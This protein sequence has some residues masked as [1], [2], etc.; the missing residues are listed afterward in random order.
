[1]RVRRSRAVGEGAWAYVADPYRLAAWWPRVARV[2]A[3]SADGWTTVLASPRGHQVRADWRLLSSDPPRRRR[4]AQELEESPF[5][6]LFLSHEVEVAVD[7][8]KVTIVIEQRVRGWARLAPWMVKRA[9]RRQADEALDG[10]AEVL[11][12]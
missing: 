12:G 4:W 9:A 8:A 10:L 1:M 2:E 6:R 11:A 3:V 5:A 7:G